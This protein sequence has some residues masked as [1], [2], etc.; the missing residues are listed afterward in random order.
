MNKFVILITQRTGSTLLWRYLDLHPEIEAHG[1]IFLKAMGRQ[2]S[3]STFIKNSNFGKLNNILRK[4][5]MISSYMEQIFPKESKSKAIGFKLMYNQNND[6]LSDLIKENDFHVIH[7]IR[8]NFLKIILSRE[9]ARKRS[10]YH[11]SNS[12]DIESI[13]IHLQSENLIDELY[14]IKKE[15]D[16]NRAVFKSTAYSEVFYEDLIA[17]KDEVTKSIINSLGL[18]LNGLSDMVFPLKKINSD[19]IEDI[20]DNYDEIKN[21][22]ENSEFRE[23]LD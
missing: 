21:I 3:Y 4:R 20:I 11:A 15:V 5:K 14:E 23:F 22:L 17:N 1:E 2:D 13:K 12:D 19:K 7:L 18:S 16:R 8:Q 10:L 6:T 9:T